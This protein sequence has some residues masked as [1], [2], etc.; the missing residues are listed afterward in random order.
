M[1]GNPDTV[2]VTVTWRS[3]EGRNYGVYAS[4]DMQGDEAWEELDDGVEGEADETS[5]TET[6]LPLGTPPEALSDP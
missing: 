3:R 2:S 5:Y 1:K 4:P 6:G